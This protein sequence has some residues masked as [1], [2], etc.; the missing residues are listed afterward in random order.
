MESTPKVVIDKCSSDESLAVSDKVQSG[1]LSTPKEA[2]VNERSSEGVSGE[3]GA[4]SMERE[5][6]ST[7]RERYK[8]HRHCF[9]GGLKER[10]I[11]L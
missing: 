11:W 8:V 2:V 7:N 6:P 1:V 4:V 10:D 9:N 5:L 3:N